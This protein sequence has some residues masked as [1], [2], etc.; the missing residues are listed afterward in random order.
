MAQTTRISGKDVFVSFNGT[1][2]S[3][4]IT[5]VEFSEEVGVIELVAADDTFVYKISNGKTN[6]SGSISALFD[7]TTQTEWDAIVAGTSGT[8]IVAPRGTAST[9]QQLL[10]TSAFIRRRGATFPYDGA[11]EMSADIEFA[12]LLTDGT[13]A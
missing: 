6:G 7:G 13:Y 12:S 4:D 9:Y 8:F 5:S 10:W 3:G 2:I 1:D 11:V